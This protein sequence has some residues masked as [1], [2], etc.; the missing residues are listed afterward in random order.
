MLF[1]ERNDFLAGH[2][3][4]GRSSCHSISK[5]AATD[6]HGL[7]RIGSVSIREIRGDFSKLAR[8]LFGPALDYNFFLSVELDGITAL[9]MHHAKEAVLPTAEWEIR[10]GCGYADVNPDISG[11]RF[12]AESSRGRTARGEQRGL[13][14]I[15]AALQKSERFVHVLGMDH[16]QH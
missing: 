9:S 7:R 11:R 4:Y 12:V 13:I 5:K 3:G 6:S 8:V 16:A 10:H 14:A 1:G 2:R 15:W